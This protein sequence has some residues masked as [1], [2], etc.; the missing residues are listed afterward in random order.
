ML[1]NKLVTFCSIEHKS[2]NPSILNFTKFI[3]FRLLFY[4]NIRC[5]NNKL[6]FFGKIF[7]FSQ[8][9]KDVFKLI[10]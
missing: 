1:P 8:H 7:R 6:E 3:Y 10:Q 5:K 9:I 2:S 4:C